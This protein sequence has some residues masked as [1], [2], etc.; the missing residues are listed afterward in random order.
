MVDTG[1]KASISW[2]SVLLKGW[3]LRNKIVVMK[4]DKEKMP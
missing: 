3:S 4:E 2:Q 1:P